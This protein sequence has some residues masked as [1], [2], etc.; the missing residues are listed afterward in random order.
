MNDGELFDKNSSWNNKAEVL[1]SD[2]SNEITN[3]KYNY[4]FFLKYFKNGNSL[5]MKQ[6]GILDFLMSY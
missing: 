6:E 1:K 3:K 5:L 4:L 2:S